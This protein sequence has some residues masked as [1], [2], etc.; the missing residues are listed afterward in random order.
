VDLMV[1][2]HAKPGRGR[3]GEGLTGI[4]GRGALVWLVNQPEHSAVQGEEGLQSETVHLGALLHTRR[5]G[6]VGTVYRAL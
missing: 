6:E 2:I 3:G 4:L 1:S 5:R